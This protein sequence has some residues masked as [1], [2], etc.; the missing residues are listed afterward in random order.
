MRKS[1]LLLILL[2]LLAL[3]CIASAATVSGTL[4]QISYNST[5]QLEK[6]TIILESKNG[7]S[8][9]AVTDKNGYYRFTNVSQGE[10]RISARLP[11]DHV[12][13]FKNENNWFLPGQRNHAVTDWFSVNGNTTVN[14]ASTRADVYV[15]FTAFVDENANGG[16][17]NSEP[18][19]KNVEISLHPADYPEITVASGLTDRK[20][21]LKLDHLSPGTY[22]VRVVFPDNYSAGPLGSKISQYYNCINPSDSQEAWSDSF[23][24]PTGSL[25]IGIGAVVTGSAQGN[26]WFDENNDGRKNAGESG[27]KDAVITLVAEDSGLTRTVKTD[28]NGNYV[29]SR[30]QPGNYSFRVTAPDGYMFTS[31]GGDSWL[32]ED[33]SNTDQGTVTIEAENSLTIP[34]VGLMKSTGLKVVFYRDDNANG[35]MDDG[36]GTYCDSEIIA[37]RNSKT[38]F[39]VSTDENGMAYI[40]IIRSGVLQ[41]VAKLK[42]GDIFSPGGLNNDFALPLAG[43]QSAIEITLEPAKIT[44]LYAAVTLPAQ[45]GG[46][47]FM[48]SD[49]DG[50]YSSQE[51]PAAGFTVQAI[52]WNGQLASTATTDAG[53]LY[54]FDSLLPIPHTIR[55][56][57]NDPYI[58]SP[59]SESGNSIVNQNSDYGETAIL[60]LYPGSFTG[61]INAGLFKAGT[62]SGRIL[63]TDDRPTGMNPGLEDVTVTLIN[64]DGSL[65]SDYT[66]VKSETDGSYYLKGILPGEYCLRYTLPEDALFEETD[67]LSVNSVSF[68]TVMGSDILMSD[69]FAVRTTTIEGQVLCEGE[70]A[71]AI[72]TAVNAENGYTVSF[73]AE[74]SSAGHFALHLLRPGTWTVTIMLEDGFSFAEDTDLVPAIAESISS[75]E[76]SFAMGDTLDNQ[77]VL[78]TRP[79]TLRGRVFLDENLSDSWNENEKL[80]TGHSI[81]LIN[82]E[83][84]TVTELYTDE[85]G[86]FDS[87]KLIPGRYQVA[88]P[89]NEDCILVKGYQSSAEIWSQ[90]VEAIGGKSNYTEIPV[91]QFASIS[92]KLWSL[93]ESLDFVGGLEVRLFNAD[94]PAV[95]VAVTKTNK[96]G[97]YHFA[98]LYPGNYCL[99]VLLP[100]G[101]GF[102][103]KADVSES[104]SSL[105]LSNDETSM[106]NV[107]CL[108]MG[109]SITDADFGFGAKGSIGDLAWL[110][111]NGNGMQDIGEPGIPGI[112][113]QL[114][115]DD[116]ILAETETDLYGHYM[117]EG[118]YPGH[119]T[120]RVYMHPELMS[121]THQTVFPLIGSVLPESDDTIVDADDVIVPSGTR[122]LAV[123]IGFMLREEG[124]YPAVMDTIPTVDWSFGGKKR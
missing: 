44:E 88:L 64:P 82:R 57:L 118:I 2:A 31:K 91:L 113:I 76:Y 14:L 87:P 95:P 29:F 7:I 102:A 97:D 28:K 4:T 47:V 69:V 68:N 96:L 55:F 65:V 72:I 25:G 78:V 22:I 23:T 108:Q 54:H 121:T 5:K 52:D 66:T 123:D 63:L 104:R 80:L 89:L 60:H 114:I 48:D 27:F 85:N 74:S 75:K 42:D 116:E 94:E 39:Q 115:Q 30:L 3:P 86:Y 19:L 46:M 73:P 83:G 16:R 41:I 71:N 20:G 119:Y 17:M 84:I 24:L 6:I 109:V 106:S 45:L 9:E 35:A 103:R 21:E 77:K 90:D 110:D 15:K 40:P 8:E 53:G 98:R 92:G 59:Y 37:I 38:I 18:L 79:A 13:A 93:D 99:N 11:S 10:Y 105:I 120:L 112:K 50:M 51:Q 101:H 61:N 56:L 117:F 33:Y 122:N 34:D 111:L 12:P 36:E 32:S 49:N 70:P 26:I 62:I 67:E 1:F 58:A 107:I 43:N 81:R 100:E 124:K